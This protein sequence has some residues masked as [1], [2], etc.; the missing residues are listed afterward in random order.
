MKDIYDKF[1][2]TNPDLILDVKDLISL[3]CNLVNKN[4]DTHVEHKIAY[5]Y[6]V[7]CSFYDVVYREPLDETVIAETDEENNYH[8]HLL[9]LFTPNCIRR[10]MKIMETDDVADFTK[11]IEDH[12]NIMFYPTLFYFVEDII[13][14]Y[15][16]EKKQ[17]VYKLFRVSFVQNPNIKCILKDAGYYLRC[18]GVQPVYVSRCVYNSLGEVT[19][20]NIPF[21]IMNLFKCASSDIFR[22]I[23]ID[24]FYLKEAVGPIQLNDLICRIITYENIKYLLLNNINHLEFLLRELSE[25]FPSIFIIMITLINPMWLI[26][27]FPDK[28][29]PLKIILREEFAVVNIYS[30]NMK[31]NYE[32]IY[33]QFYEIMETLTNNSIVLREHGINVLTE[34]RVI[35]R[36]E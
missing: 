23:I 12:I 13:M 30:Q 7:M 35:K 34:F 27:N 2:H 17:R 5:L 25:I 36:K 18:W 15:S 24:I 33:N 10:L 29:I 32:N 26:E 22:S 28:I 8:T 16:T 1:L 21:Y 3:V 19:S 4:V 9:R 6:H 11:F 20:D 31:T 14:M